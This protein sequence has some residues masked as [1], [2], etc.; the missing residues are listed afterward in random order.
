VD[1]VWEAIKSCNVKVETF[2]RSSW[3]GREKKVDAKIISDAVE[4]AIDAF[5]GGTPSE[6][7]IVSGDSDIQ[8]AVEKIAKRGFIVHVWS[9]EN[10]LSNDYKHQTNELVRVHRLDPYLDQIGFHN[11]QWRGEQKNIPLQSAVV[12]DAA[13]KAEEINE[14]TS[15]LS[16]PFRRYELDK[17]RDGASSHDLVIIHAL[18]SSSAMDYDAREYFFQL[19]KKGLSKHGLTVLSYQ[20]YAQKHPNSTAKLAISN[21]FQELPDGVSGDEAYYYGTPKADGANSEEGSIPSINTTDYQVVDRSTTKKKERAKLSEI[22]SQKRCDRRKYCHWELSCGFGHTD[23]ER[24]RFQAYGH[25]K[26]KKVKLCTFQDCTKGV[27]CRFAH[28]AAELFCPTCEKTG[29][30][31]MVD[32]P[33]RANNIYRN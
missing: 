29:V 21:R 1:T 26:A 13:P 15:R 19:C 22:R 24:K 7:V 8:T 33:D 23:E 30:H 28:G 14:F 6:F 11:N 12:L 27:K 4:A 3:S 32:C 25:V 10:C 18:A 20:E 16:H 2:E 17:I 5:Y 9:W 31:N